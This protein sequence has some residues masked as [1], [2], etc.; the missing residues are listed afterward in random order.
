MASRR[1]T[2][3]S[4]ARH[5]PAAG[6]HRYADTARLAKAALL[7]ALC[8]GF[9]ALSLMQHQ[10]RAFFLCYFLFVAMGMLLNVNVN[11]DASH[12]AFLRAPRANRPWGGW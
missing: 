1:F 5:T 7:L 3:I 8:V 2:A 9:Y 12:N 4:S 10:P 6:D 11:H